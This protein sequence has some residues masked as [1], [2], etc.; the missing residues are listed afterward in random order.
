[1][2]NSAEKHFLLCTTCIVCI[3]N[4][5]APTT[6]RPYRALI[7]RS[8]TTHWT[9]S[10][11]W[12]AWW[13]SGRLYTETS[14]SRRTSLWPS[15]RSACRYQQ[16][17]NHCYNCWHWYS[18]IEIINSVIRHSVFLLYISISIS[19]IVYDVE[20]QQY[21]VSFFYFWFGVTSYLYSF[22]LS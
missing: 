12:S 3:F 14:C 22:L 15:W 8:W 2:W 20:E 21:V 19:V 9:T 5:C 11:G 18:V 17:F 4:C 16:H 10:A 6:L 1:M 13:C 7:R